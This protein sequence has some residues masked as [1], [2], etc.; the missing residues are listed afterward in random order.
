MARHLKGLWYCSLV[1]L[2]FP[3]LDLL[4][5]IFKVMA[6]NIAPN[7]Q[8]D[9]YAS[10]LKKKFFSLAD[11]ALHSMTGLSEAATKRRLLDIAD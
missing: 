9:R 3:F 8:Y 2:L 11:V 5:L 10:L 1:E 6:K 7:S 4:G